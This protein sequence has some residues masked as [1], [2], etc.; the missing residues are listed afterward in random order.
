MIDGIEPEVRLVE[1]FFSLGQDALF[2]S[3]MKHSLHSFQSMY[4]ESNEKKQHDP[5]KRTCYSVDR[6]PI[7]HSRKSEA[8]QTT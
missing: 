6:E 3:D 1:Y 8:L 2:R 5:M 7:E 4:Q